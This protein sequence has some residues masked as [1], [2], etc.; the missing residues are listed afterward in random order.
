[1]NDKSPNQMFGFQVFLHYQQF[2]YFLNEKIK[3][4]FASPNNFEIEI[5]IIK[6]KTRCFKDF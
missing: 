1:M 2:I 5:N 6:S 4:E 3:L